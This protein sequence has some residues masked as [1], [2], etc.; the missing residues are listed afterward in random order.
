MGVWFSVAK[1]A[2]STLVLVALPAFVFSSCGGGG[3]SGSGESDPGQSIVSASAPTEFRV[4][5]PLSSEQ[6]G[7]LK[8]VPNLVA[9]VTGIGG[10]V[11]A[12]SETLNLSTLGSGQGAAR[13]EGANPPGLA[14][15]VRFNT[16]LSK[17]AAL[18]SGSVTV[19]I[20]QKAS[21][22]PRVL[23]SVEVT[24]T[25][26]SG[27]DK[28]VQV[29]VG[30]IQVPDSD[31]DG[32]SDLIEIAVSAVTGRSF[33]PNKAD[34]TPV[35][36]DLQEAAAKFTQN[37]E[38][39]V[40]ADTGQ[41]VTINLD[42]FPPDTTVTASI[43]LSSA[44][45]KSPTF[46]LGCTEVPCTF[47][48]SLDGAAFAVCSSPY[49]LN[50]SP[51]DG[52][53]KLSVRAKDASG[54]VDPTPADAAW[55]VDLTPPDTTVKLT[56]VDPST[57]VFDLSCTD[58]KCSFSCS[59]D[60]KALASCSSPL[61]V[62]SLTT[63]KHTFSAA[64]SDVLG[65]KDASPASIEF[66]VPAP[67]PPP[68]PDTTYLK[69]LTFSGMSSGYSA[70]LSWTSNQGPTAEFKLYWDKDDGNEPF[71]GKLEGSLKDSPMSLTSTAF[72]SWK[73]SNG[74]TIYSYFLWTY[75]LTA[76]QSY[77]FALSGYDGVPKLEGALSTAIT[78]VPTLWAPTL[79]CFAGGGTG[80]TLVWDTVKD[81]TAYEYC[82][83]TSSTGCTGSSATYTSA[84]AATSVTL[85][86]LQS[87]T[88][89][90]ATVRAVAGSA[91]GSASYLAT[92]VTAQAEAGWPKCGGSTGLF[93]NADGDASLEGLLVSGD[94]VTL[95]NHDGATA[96]GW[97]KTPFTKGAGT[98]A[99]PIGS[100]DSDAVSEVVA[101]SGSDITLLDG[102]GTVLTGWPKSGVVSPLLSYLSNLDA[103]FA[104]GT[105]SAILTADVT[106]DG[107]AELL[108]PTG[109]TDLTAYKK[110]GT[111]V[112]GWPLTLPGT[113]MYLLGT[114]GWANLDA[115]A[116]QEFL[117]I[118]MSSNWELKIF[119]YNTDRTVVAGWPR[120]PV[121][122][123]LSVTGMAVPVIGDVDG[124]GEN[125]VI[126]G[127]NKQVLVYNRD[128]TAA[129]GFPKTLSG[130]VYV[131]PAL[132]DLDGDTYPEIIM[133]DLAGSIHVIDGDGTLLSGWPVS[134]GIAPSVNTVAVDIDNDGVAEILAVGEKAGGKWELTALKANGAVVS[135]FPKVI[136]AAEGLLSVA[137]LDGDGTAEANYT[138]GDS[139]TVIDLG[140]NSF[141]AAV[142]PWPMPFK[143]IQ[144]H[145][146][147]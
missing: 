32:V 134:I 69:V 44:T 140:A 57:A 18:A 77:F 82:V 97:P 6:L 49:T 125:E 3:G 93:A 129:T 144:H 131:A 56:S 55:T 19:T 13:R 20:Q 9:R 75:N 1:G 33:D 5:I 70:M 89:Y 47:E 117:V 127:V 8:S 4:E 88:L 100:L 116:D 133:Q 136:G 84:G 94:I 52:N 63:G 104:L 27:A 72:D 61:T 145:A 10:E 48:C 112:S 11:L 2:L 66:D 23:V 85:S 86:S 111:I 41:T 60:A 34:S 119:A 62:P 142:A 113:E 124:D 7:A 126:C 141:N 51:A 15:G 121:T 115:D 110:D 128:G 28:T 90:Y 53:H 45:N 138:Q 54:N 26:P 123:I 99:T 58:A 14:L 147:Y 130:D 79:E 146:A 40:K 95:V 92:T 31:G 36:K 42:K 114:L 37:L 67:P 38:K 135:G 105:L 43:S 16:D 78:I 87:D 80:A 102:S 12:E 106:G 68:P 120:T 35:I 81:A 108:V 91:A 21:G 143:N 98:V 74:K 96:T 24:L 118:S 73:D 64:A 122:D 46:T 39:A 137:D 22:Q 83:S 103:I 65:N 29:H 50:A 109:D 101:L 59:V 25:L 139:L 76:G 17:I 107:A 71:S 30:S 132:A